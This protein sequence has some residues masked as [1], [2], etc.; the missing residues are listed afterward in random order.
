MNIIL[1]EYE[2]INTYINDKLQ[3]LPTSMINFNSGDNNFTSSIKHVN[4][5]KCG[6]KQKD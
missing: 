5:H 4:I 3:F 6:N 2:F 1:Y